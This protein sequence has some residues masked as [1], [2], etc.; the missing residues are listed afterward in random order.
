MDKT[1]VSQKA[2]LIVEKGYALRDPVAPVFIAK[3][4]S[5][6][7]KLGENVTLDCASN[8]YPQPIVVWLKD[9]T[10]LDLQ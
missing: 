1:K 2:T 6:I 7:A 8:G 4:K 3:P 9:G 10:T 5:V